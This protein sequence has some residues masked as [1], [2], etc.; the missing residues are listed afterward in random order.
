MIL[1]DRS[2]CEEAK[3]PLVKGT[4]VFT[5]RNSAPF[6]VRGYQYHRCELCG[7]EFVDLETDKVNQPLIQ[8]ARDKANQSQCGAGK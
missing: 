7:F 2:K 3:K 1:C 4:E 5:P 6:V 8:V